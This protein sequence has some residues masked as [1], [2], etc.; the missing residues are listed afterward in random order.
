MA[1]RAK[2]QRPSGAAARR[3]S[4]LIRVGSGFMLYPIVLGPRHIPVARPRA[5]RPHRSDWRRY[6]QAA[7]I[8]DLVWE[9]P[10]EFT[11]EHGHIGMAALQAHL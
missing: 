8:A 9:A 3:A 2:R 11:D 4:R 10:A 1:L 6:R 7:E 5:S